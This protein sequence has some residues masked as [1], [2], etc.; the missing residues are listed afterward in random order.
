M[1]LLGSLNQAKLERMMTSYNRIHDTILNSSKPILDTKTPRH[2]DTRTPGHQDTRTPGHQDTR[3]P[4]NHG[5]HQKTLSILSDEDI[6]VHIRECFTTAPIELQNPEQLTN[7]LAEQY[8]ST[9]LLEGNGNDR[10]EHVSVHSY[11]KKL[12]VP[13]WAVV[14]F[15]QPNTHGR[16][17]CRGPGSSRVL[18]LTL[19]LPGFDQQHLSWILR[20]I[21][22]KSRVHR[23]MPGPP[24]NTSVLHEQDATLVATATDG[25]KLSVGS[26]VSGY[27]S[28]LARHQAGNIAHPCPVPDEC[29]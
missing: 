16:V 9:L 26:S 8:Y 11:H 5:K 20:G 29:C 25:T 19:P 4:P 1:L 6:S 14:H 21:H 23:W 2:Q 3:T 28:S 10:K 22:G 7:W 24:T 15:A 17:D 27:S 12:D 13:M 18:A